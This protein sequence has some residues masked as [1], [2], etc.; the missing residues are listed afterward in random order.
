MFWLTVLLF[1][2]LPST[3]SNASG[4]Y[5]AGALGSPAGEGFSQAQINFQN[6]I[7]TAY[8]DNRMQLWES[9]LQAMEGEYLRNPSGSLLYDVTLAQYGLIG[10]YLG[11]NENSKAA[12][13]LKRSDAYIEELEGTA[14]YEAEA[15][16]FRAAYYAYRIALNPWRSIQF[17]R[18]S[19][20]LIDETLEMHTPYPRAYIEKGNMLFYAPS[21]LGG[22]KTEAIEYYKKALEIFERDLQN[23]HRWLYL[24][25]FVFLANAYQQTGNNSGAINTLEKALEYEPNFRWIRE[26][27]L[28]ELKSQSE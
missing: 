6:L 1:S 14:G 2:L 21:M 17:G 27:M 22:S 24:S 23:N 7:Y 11:T 13:L 16:L 19:G 8:T 9:T 20:R 10:Y 28:P 25:T 12:A 26:E 4:N 15:K 18:T 3:V 5:T